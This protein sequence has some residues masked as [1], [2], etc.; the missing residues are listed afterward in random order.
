MVFYLKQSVLACLALSFGM[1]KALTGE[2]MSSLIVMMPLSF[3]QELSATWYTP[4][5]G[6]GACGAPLQN[7]EH[8][9]AL[10]SDQYAKGS[11]CGR[12]VQ[13]YCKYVPLSVSF[14]TD[15]ILSQTKKSL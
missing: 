5:G 3:S 11:T 1:V 15:R 4:N 9:V 2:G 12:R 6:L 10:S 14:Q 13:V 8:I 7:F